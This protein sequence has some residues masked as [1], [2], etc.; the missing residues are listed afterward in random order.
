MFKS[1]TILTR[2][3]AVVVQLSPFSPINKFDHS[4]CLS[5]NLA[6]SIGQKGARNIHNEQQTV[7]YQQ[8]EKERRLYRKE[9]RA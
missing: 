2:V 7:K 8:E 4:L 6:F 9:I 5:T 3:S 1:A